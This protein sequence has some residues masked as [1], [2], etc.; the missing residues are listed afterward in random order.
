MK[1]VSTKSLLERLLVR[2][3]SASPS[4]P[5]GNGGGDVGFGSFQRGFGL[6]LPFGLG[7]CNLVQEG[8]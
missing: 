5:F 6:P 1:L 7:V 8:A 4:R 3:L 2:W